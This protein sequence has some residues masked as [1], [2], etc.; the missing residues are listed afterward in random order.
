MR[1][2]IGEPTWKTLDNETV[3][4]L[5][6]QELQ[7][8]LPAL[9]ELYAVTIRVA[10]EEDSRAA[11]HSVGLAL[12]IHTAGLF[13]LSGYRVD[14]FHGEGDVTV[15]FAQRVGFFAPVVQGQFQARF[16]VAR[17]GEKG[18]GCISADGYL[19]SKLE[20]Q[21]V[22]VEVYATV[23]IQNAVAGVNV[24]HVSS[25]SGLGSILARRAGLSFLYFAD[26]RLGHDLS[27][28][29]EEEAPVTDSHELKMRLENSL[30]AD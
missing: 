25:S 29:R 30:R 20:A 18:V 21:F 4:M 26:L 27:S 7:N 15:A 3:E 22:G 10:D 23:E 1:L 13:K 9:D 8:S 11:A 5:V 14:V 17:N 19:S 28:R 2:S 24:L 12:E 6:G 16:G